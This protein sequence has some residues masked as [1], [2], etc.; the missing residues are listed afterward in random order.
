M[1]FQTRPNGP[2]RLK[3]VFFG[4]K[5]NDQ[6]MPKIAVEFEDGKISAIEWL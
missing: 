6:M 3:K 2:H 5:E 4:Y 1:R